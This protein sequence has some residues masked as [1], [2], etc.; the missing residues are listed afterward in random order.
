[1]SSDVD[2]DQVLPD[3][4]QKLEIVPVY[5][6]SQSACKSNNE[7]NQNPFFSVL[8]TANG[9]DDRIIKDLFGPTCS[10]C[11]SSD[12]SSCDMDSVNS[13]SGSKDVSNKS[14]RHRGSSVSQCIEHSINKQI[15]FKHR[16][17]EKS[18]VLSDKKLTILREPILKSIGRSAYHNGNQSKS[19]CEPK[20]SIEH[21]GNSAK[22]SDLSNSTNPTVW[23]ALKSQC[24]NGGGGDDD[25]Q[26]A[27]G[28]LKANCTI[29]KSGAAELSTTKV[30]GECQHVVPGTSVDANNVMIHRIQNWQ[31]NDDSTVDFKSLVN[32]CDNLTLSTRDG[33]ISSITELHKTKNFQVLQSNQ[34]GGNIGVGTASSTGA[35]DTNSPNNSIHATMATATT[36]TVLAGTGT[37]S[38]AMNSSLSS[39]S[40]NSS[41][42]SQQ[43]RMNSSNCDVTIDELASYIEFQ[44][45]LP[46]PMSSNVYEAMF[47]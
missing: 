13:S 12:N 23:F 15:H 18:Q 2:D 24:G 3:S 34:M 16:D 39:N 4:L 41:S 31:L 40:S 5:S 10:N 19:C 11:E 47:S 35:T 14:W 29:T 7:R 22:N 1:M 37:S 44:L 27:N 45:H 28:Q 30:V 38:N 36:A 25:D 43:A 20:S 9:I 26:G 46:K 8:S 33:S 6:H 17:K 32:E 42:C 21:S